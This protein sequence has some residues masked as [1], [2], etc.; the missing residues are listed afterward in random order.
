MAEHLA[1]IEQLPAQGMIAIRADLALLGERIAQAA[2]VALPAQTRIA[3][4]GARSLGWMSPD[5]LLLIVPQD[6]LAATLAA[7]NSAVAGEHALIADVSDM[8]AGFII[9]GAKPAQVLAK[10][11]PVDF[12]ALPPG[13]LRRTRAAQVACALWQSGDDA[14]TIIAFRSVGNYLRA[15]LDNAALPGTGL[16]PR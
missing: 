13:T 4:E 1:Q 11:C 2:G 15:L 16:D 3:T 14:F 7:L 5:E 6:E 8:R 9:R 12:A 10:L